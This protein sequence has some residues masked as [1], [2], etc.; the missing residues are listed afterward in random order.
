MDISYYTRQL[1]QV[2]FAPYVFQ[3]TV[4][5][6]ARQVIEAALKRHTPPQ[7]DAAYNTWYIKYTFGAYSAFR[8]TW[9]G[10]QLQAP[11]PEDM[12]AKID[13]EYNPQSE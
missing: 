7:V 3:S 9:V 11:T 1:P 10:H 2:K 4:S 6:E 5:R 13:A 8:Y 12:A